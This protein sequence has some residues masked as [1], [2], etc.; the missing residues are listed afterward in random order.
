MV[1][2]T[3]IRLWQYLLGNSFIFFQELFQEFP[4]IFAN[5]W[6]NKKPDVN[7]SNNII[8]WTE[9]KAMNSAILKHKITNKQ[10]VI[11]STA[12]MSNHIRTFF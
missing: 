2:I 12:N 4:L 6:T 7:V 5:V 1:W 11:S 8:F 9:R 3:S 10:K